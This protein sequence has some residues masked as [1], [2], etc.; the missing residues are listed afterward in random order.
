MYPPAPPPPPIEPP[1]P[2]PAIIRS[3]TGRLN[4]EPLAD[5]PT[6]ANSRVAAPGVVKVWILY[7][8]AVVT[9]PPV[10]TALVELGINLGKGRFANP[11]FPRTLLTNGI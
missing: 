4:S 1:P 3:S 10:A 7:P 11:K 9:V 2:P 6:G 8:P 5:P